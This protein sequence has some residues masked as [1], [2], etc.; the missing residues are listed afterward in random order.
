MD[1]FV[2]LEY[3]AP[4][5]VCMCKHRIIYARKIAKTSVVHTNIVKILKILKKKKPSTF[6]LE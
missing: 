3:E 1:F 6:E 4:Q 5:E 2:A